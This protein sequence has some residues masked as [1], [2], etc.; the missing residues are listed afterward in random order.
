MDF[1][2]LPE[3]WEWVALIIGIVTLI[4]VTVSII[5]MAFGGPKVRIFFEK[6]DKEYGRYLVCQLNNEPI[7][8]GILK[9]LM[10]RREVARNVT[11]GFEIIEQRTNQ[12]ICPIMQV[13]IK[14]LANVASFRVSLLASFIPAEFAI[15]GYDRENK[16]VV[17]FKEPKQVLSVGAYK[18]K[19]EVLV[20]AKLLKDECDFIVRDIYPFIHW[21]FIK[22]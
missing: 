21:E 22:P 20:G 10:V 7:H 1:N 17:I 18:V 2:T 15:A 3:Q 8:K 13:V 9:Y 6:V 12:V 16:E 11:A 14:T 5:R 19:V 4:L